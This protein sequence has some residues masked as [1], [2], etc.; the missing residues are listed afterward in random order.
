MQY[1]EPAAIGRKRDTREADKRKCKLCNFT[2]YS[3]HALQEH[4]EICHGYISK[5]SSKYSQEPAVIELHPSPGEVLIEPTGVQ[6]PPTKRPALNIKGITSRSSRKNNAAYGQGRH[7][8]N[9]R[10][11]A[12]VSSP[13]EE[14]VAPTAPQEVAVAPPTASPP[15]PPGPPAPPAQPATPNAVTPPTAPADLEDDL[16]LTS[17]SDSEEEHSTKDK[18]TQTDLPGLTALEEALLTTVSLLRGTMNVPPRV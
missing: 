6:P 2:T 4:K 10:T 12:T 15:T 7:M 3:W 11:P 16:I 5:G 1:T 9:S 13:L 8:N 14:L 17:D 18:D